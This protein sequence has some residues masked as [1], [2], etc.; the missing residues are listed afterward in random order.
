MV[1]VPPDPLKDQPGHIIRWYS[2]ATDIEDRKRAEEEIRK[3]NIALREE[4]V[5]TSMF[6]E[7]VGTSP[8]LRKVFLEV[9]KVA[10]TDQRCS[11]PAKQERVR[12][13]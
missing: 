12:K 8:A 1:S 6:E 7:I 5:K 13:S 4:I 10:P 9:G 11:S 3:E 2:T